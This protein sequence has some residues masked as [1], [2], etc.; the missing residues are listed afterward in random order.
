MSRIGASDAD[1]WLARAPVSRVNYDE[2]ADYYDSIYGESDDGWPFWT[3]FLAGARTVVEVGAG[4]GRFTALVASVADR[5]IAIE[6]SLA[7]LE[8]ARGR[9]ATNSRVEAVHGSATS[10]PVDN[11]IASHVLL[12]YGVLTY[13]LSPADQLTAIRE[14]H[15]VLEPGGYMAVDVNY[16]PLT[17]PHSAGS[18]AL[19]LNSVS[20]H[21][22][23]RLFVTGDSTLDPDWNVCRYNEIIDEVAASGSCKRTVVHHDVHL[24]TPF[25]IYLLVLAGGFDLEALYGGFD[26]SHPT[27]NS[28]RLIGIGKKL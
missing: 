20:S 1:L 26:R 12:A 24:F 5:V 6:P 8:R 16:Y 27:R 19:R 21:G 25:E 10:L 18:T 23:S 2:E 3:E 7:M 17:H 22:E 13:L 11:G 28:K 15:R 14:A 9:H 4:T